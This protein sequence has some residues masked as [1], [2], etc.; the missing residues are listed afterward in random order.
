MQKKI[1]ALAIAAAFSAP[2][3]AD[4]TIY[5]VLDGGYGD[6]SKT[7]TTPAGVGTKTGQ[8]AIAF[9]QATSS[10]LGFV[11]SED[12]SNGMKAT[13]KVESGLGSNPLAGVG[14]TGT[15]AIAFNGT[16]IDATSLGNRELNLTLALGEG[17]SI[18]AGYGSTPI[19]D[20]T[21]AYDSALGGNLVGNLITN[22]VATANNRAT[23][24]DVIHQFGPLKATVGVMRNTDHSDGKTDVQKGNGYQFAAQ[25]AQDALS[26]GCCLPKRRIG[27]KYCCCCT[28]VPGN[29]G[30]AAVT[31]SDVTT[32]VMIVG[33]SYDLSVV[34][35]TA[36]YAN[37][38]TDD[39]LTV[40]AKGA[41]K[42][43]MEN[44]GVSVPLG[45]ATAFAQISAGTQDQATTAGAASNSRKLSG[46][47]VGAKYNLSK[48]T[49]A[50]AAT[51]QTE[52]KEAVGT[53][54]TGIK[55]NQYAIG[56]VKTF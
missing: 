8:T 25:F 14:Q 22:D 42:R 24:V 35:L 5:G 34:K 53:A 15:S 7:L 10:R 48:T 44:I 20:F 33:A 27:C 6:T 13:F 2:A 46:Y 16:T 38:K 55:V 56:L 52:L 41:G 32:K 4:T 23:S 40:N 3:F 19:R 11:A 45:A 21:F 1:I 37:V 43:S 18:K 54:D 30:T 17:T 39:A 51:G 26:I 49:W 28:A 12:L 31:G 36:Q 50:Y 47:T 9:S 29:A